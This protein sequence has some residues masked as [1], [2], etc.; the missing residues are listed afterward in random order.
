[1]FDAGA[2]LFELVGFSTQAIDLCEPG[3]AGPYLMPNHVAGDQLAIQFV[4][5]NRMRS[6]ADDTHAAL[7]NVD[8]LRQLV[9]RRLAQKSTQRCHAM[10]IA[11]GLRDLVTVLEYLHGA[12]LVDQNLFAVEAVTSLPEQHRSARSQLY[13]QGDRQHEGRYQNQNQRRE[14]D[15]AGTL[16]KPVCAVEWRFTYGKHRNA[17]DRFH[18]RLDKVVQKN[19]RHKIHRRS[20]VMK[21]TQQSQNARLRS[22]GQRDVNQ[23]DVVPLDILGKLAQIAEIV[24]N[25]KVQVTV[26]AAIVE[27]PF[28]TNA[29][30][31][32]GAQAH[33]E[34]TPRSVCAR[35]Y[36]R[37][38]QTFCGKYPRQYQWNYPVRGKQG[39]RRDQRPRKDSVGIEIFHC[40]GSPPQQQQKRHY[41][42]PA[43][44][45][46][47]DQRAIA[48]GIACEVA[49]KGHR[50]YKQSQN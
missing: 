4:V 43:G 36:G 32:T 1:M 31:R 23:I 16:D 27:I 26:P 22:H 44:D 18:A 42:K 20:C 5:R 46:A 47:A 10:I 29:K 25:L 6:R 28:K 13:R 30:Q 49:R 7:Q 11:C 12:K 50:K 35:D 8:E 17:A 19:I 40:L 45:D 33:A 24:I 9:Q 2:H 39:E 34:V 41:R 21:V 15:V 3:D 37:P 48:S 38:L 14:N